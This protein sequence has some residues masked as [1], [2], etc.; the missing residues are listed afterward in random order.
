M[1]KQVQIMVETG[2]GTRPLTKDVILT[3]RRIRVYTIGWLRYMTHLADVT[4]RGWE[5]EGILPKPI[6]K[7]PGNTRWYTSAELMVYTAL[8]RQHYQSGRNMPKL[9][10]NL[11]EACIKI[12]KNYM[13]PN[14]K[15]APEM[16]ALQNEQELSNSF[17]RTKLK[18]KLSKEKFYEVD[19]IIK[20]VCEGNKATGN[21]APHSNG[22]SVK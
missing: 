12:R 14:L 13:T 15:V 19:Q 11:A 17:D 3:G 7:L 6:C 18:D 21:P 9:R 5:R 4:L 10:Q 22:A 2:N 8:I 1:R 20:S 16:L